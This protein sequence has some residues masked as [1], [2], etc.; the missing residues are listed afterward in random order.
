MKARL[1]FLLRGSMFLDLKDEALC[2]PRSGDAGEDRWA[3]NRESYRH[4]TLLRRRTH[5]HC[6]D[7]IQGP[8]RYSSVPVEGGSHR[9]AKA[10]PPAHIEKGRLHHPCGSLHQLTAG[11]VKV[12]LQRRCL[13]AR[14]AVLPAPA[15]A[16]LV[17]GTV[18]PRCG[19]CSAFSVST[20]DRGQH[21][22]AGQTQV[23]HHLLQGPLGYNVQV[24]CCPVQ[25]L[26]RQPVLQKPASKGRSVPGK[27]MVSKADVMGHQKD[28]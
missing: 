24:I 2:D 1:P 19:L 5:S 18:A 23:T 7:R 15:L 22:A 10:L 17:A 20:W 9:G 11:W 21:S 12:G 26:A 28:C 16:A 8:A 13:A 3:E 27:M 6:N 25:F 4:V 14:R